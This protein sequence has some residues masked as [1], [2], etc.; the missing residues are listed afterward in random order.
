MARDYR[1]VID[2]EALEAL[3][4]SGR[5][6]EAVVHFLRTLGAFAHYGGDFQ[7]SDPETQRAFEV[8]VIRGFAIT[9]WVDAP[10]ASLKKDTIRRLGERSIASFR[11]TP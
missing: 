11:R 3:P 1:V 10:V 5:R 2:F 8:T 9:W 4:R 7:L 6:R